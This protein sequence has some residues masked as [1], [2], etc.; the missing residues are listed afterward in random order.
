M[1]LSYVWM[2]MIY[3][4]ANTKRHKA[5][6]IIGFVVMSICLHYLPIL[7]PWS[8][9]TSFLCAAL[10][11]IGYEGRQFFMNGKGLPATVFTILWVLLLP[12]F[13]GS[14][15][16][17]AYYGQY[18]VASVLMFVFIAICETY[19]LSFITQKVQCLWISKALAYIGQQSL[20][21]MCTHLII[22]LKVYG[23][24]NA[25][26][27]AA[28][29]NKCLLLAIAFTT[30]LVINAIIDYCINKLKAKVQIINYL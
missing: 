23:F 22:Y 27:P 3:S 11:A 8:L 25:H 29:A 17:I 21:L 26:F 6:T 7:L 18:G 5:L 24:L 19:S 14:N 15:I 20:R 16:S 1:F 9:D 4:R 13:G 12:Y 2:Y 28:C 30:I 10:I